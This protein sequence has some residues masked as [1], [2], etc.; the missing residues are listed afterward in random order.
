MRYFLY[1]LLAAGLAVGFLLLSQVYPDNYVKVYLGGYVVEM[2]F[3]GFLMLATIGVISFY[4]LVRF[5]RTI[6][7]APTL[8][9]RWRQRRKVI[10]SDRDLGSGYLSLIKGDWHA[11]E[12]RL[13]VH[14]DDSPVPYVSYLAAAQA[15]QEQGKLTQRDE[16]LS[17]AYKAAPK[18]TL[19]IGLTKARLH[20]A[21]GQWNMARATLED[22]YSLGKNNAQYTAMLM[23]IH[24]HS[25]NWADAKALLP[26]ARKQQALPDEQLQKIDDEVYIESL[27]TAIDLD[28]AWKALPRAQ[29]KKSNIIARYCGHLIEAQR[30]A[31]AEK[32]IVSAMKNEWDDNLVELFARL[33]SK[34]PVKARRVAEGWLMAQPDNA[35][36][37]LAAGHHALAEKNTELAKKYLQAA[38]TF[39]QLPEAYRLLG[40]LFESA[41]ERAKALQLFKSGLLVK[42][43]EPS[44]R[45]LALNSQK[46]S[47]KRSN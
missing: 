28:A 8:F 13:T 20:Q 40:E 7:F 24:Q 17:R 25:G 16:Y 30:D 22:I 2:S 47:A 46:S 9:G 3:I 23:Q 44:T 45:P 5:V 14:A 32:L 42:Q 37:N 36:A 35:F 27:K 31:E 21:A 43:D 33:D 6:I 11:A 38:I 1:T 4:F 19:A 18:E 34:S 10:V 15:A 41:D 12:K 29:R 39:G 26:L